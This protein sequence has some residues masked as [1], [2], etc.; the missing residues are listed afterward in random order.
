MLEVVPEPD[1]PYDSQ[2][3]SIR[4]KGSVIG[5]IPRGRTKTYWP[6]VARVAE[7]GKIAR[8][9]GKIYSNPSADYF[10]VSVHLLAGDKA[11]EG[12]AGL[13]PKSSSYSVP[14]A[15]SKDPSRKS[16]SGVTF[17]QAEI[18]AEI[19]RRRGSTSSPSPELPASRSTLG[20]VH[21]GCVTPLIATSVIILIA[22][23]LTGLG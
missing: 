8:V 3:I 15:F 6:V 4:Y 14:D 11:L 18:D 5:Y 9:Q 2:A 10:E 19:A 12:V 13:V 22:L 23:L 20:Y 17:T 21:L 16:V 7:S 1:N